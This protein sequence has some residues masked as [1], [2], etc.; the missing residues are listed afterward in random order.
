L[1]K[2]QDATK[3]LKLKSDE[4]ALFNGVNYGTAWNSL[5]SMKK[6][7][8]RIKADPRF[9]QFIADTAKR[10]TD[11]RAGELIAVRNHANI[12][13][14]IAK[15]GVSAVDLD[16]IINGMRLKGEW[17]VK[18]G[19]PQAV[20]NTCWAFATL[21]VHA[22]SLFAAVDKRGQRL[23]ENGTPQGLSNV[24]WAF[25]TLGVHAPSLFNAVDKRGEWLV[26]S[27]KPQEVANTC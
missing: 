21:G 13:H 12:M 3:L 11:D 20:A 5:A 7:H 23:V 9:R 1:K 25:A 22:P 16:S 24:C 19:D 15:L 14:S 8:G 17:I 27:A 26:E 4:V 2:N 10:I 18:N 6:H